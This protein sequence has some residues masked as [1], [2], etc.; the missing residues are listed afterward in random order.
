MAH[1]GYKGKNKVKVF[2]NILKPKDQDL[3]IRAYYIHN[4]IGEPFISFDM[5][6]NY[7]LELLTVATHLGIKIEQLEI[8]KRG[9]NNY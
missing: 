5:G 8:I 2:Y 3:N 1:R 7:E 9:R 4:Y 6:Q